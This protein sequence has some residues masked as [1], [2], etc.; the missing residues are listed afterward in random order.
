MV[1]C[2]RLLVW[3]FRPPV[4]GILL[5]SG[6]QWDSEWD[7]WVS[8]TI[9]ACHFLI[10]AGVLLPSRHCLV[11]CAAA[12]LL[13]A[14][15]TQVIVHPSASIVDVHNLLPSP[16]PSMMRSFALWRDR[17]AGLCRSWYQ[18]CWGCQ[19]TTSKSS[20]MFNTFLLPLC[21]HLHLLN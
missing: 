3:S 4:D 2:L 19:T 1:C 18:G 6:I 7:S 16:D 10:A 11:A 8:L 12:A 9:M 13:V 14:A 15:M 5:R 21:I 17:Y 20:V